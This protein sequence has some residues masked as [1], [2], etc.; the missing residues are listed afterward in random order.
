M[1]VM[2]ANTEPKGKE[3]RRVGAV[4]WEIVGHAWLAPSPFIILS[5]YL[6]TPIKVVGGVWQV[7]RNGGRKGNPGR[8]NSLS[9]AKLC[10]IIRKEQA[11]VV[12]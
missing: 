11:V 7:L 12:T 4:R 9:K 10:S 3:E 2:E 6:R 1:A 5:I 8:A